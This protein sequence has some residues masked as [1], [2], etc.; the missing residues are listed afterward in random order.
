MQRLKPDLSA[1]P[2]DTKFNSFKILIVAQSNYG[3]SY[4]IN[5]LVEEYVP[6]FIK[7]D[8]VLY[9]GKTVKSD[10]NARKMITYMQ[11]YKKNWG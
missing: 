7:A 8:H 9:F 1:K 3:K 10:E 6:K 11:K 5:E 4:L 2:D